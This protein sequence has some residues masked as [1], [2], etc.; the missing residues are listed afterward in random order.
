M[1][2]RQVLSISLPSSEVHHLQALSEDMEILCCNDLYSDVTFLVEDTK[3]PAHKV[4]LA[5]R[6]QYFRALLYGGLRESSEDVIELQDASKEAFTHVLRY[7]YAGCLSLSSFKEELLLEILGLSHKY[8]VGDLELA[9]CENLKT[10]LSLE[11]VCSIYDTAVLFS[12]ESL[13]NAALRFIDGRATDIMR[14]ESF[15]E[16]SPESLKSIFSRDSFYASE[17]EIFNSVC[18]WAR[19][20]PAERNNIPTI[21]ESVRFPLM[22]RLDLLNIVR[23]SGLVSP[24]MILDAM[25]QKETVK[26]TDLRRRGIIQPEENV[27]TSR[28]GATVEEGEMK[29]ALLDGDICNYDS[30]RGYTR[31]PI[32]EG[33]KG[34][35]IKLGAPHILNHFKMLLWDRDLRMYSYYIEVSID[36][37]QWT[38]VID[39][40]GVHCRSWQYLYFQEKVVRYIRIIGTFNSV[41]R[42]FHA[43][44]FQASYA[45]DIPELENGIIGPTYNVATVKLSAAMIEGVSRTRNALINESYTNYD[46]ENGY[47]CHQIGTGWLVIHL[48]QPY[49]ADSMR[50]LLWDCDD[51][52]YSYYIE[53]S[54]N[55]RDWTMVHDKTRERCRSWQHIRFEKRSFCYVRI[56]GTHNTANDVFHCVHFECPA[57]VS[58][59][60]KSLPPVQEASQ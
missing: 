32:E 2:R 37:S 36:D 59:M 40:T 38:R 60:D 49:A 9:I 7:L 46:W 57:Q 23:A 54:D 3:I 24:D 28:Y 30:E 56:V 51:R 6:S 18:E 20:N 52:Q 13:A 5:A 25:L 34:I 35:K 39:H 10:N 48:G 43:V 17:V 53:V 14:Q 12:L 22:T 1:S 15:K 27:A 44:A 21:L 4:I 33:T 16:L 41:N 47:T 29:S 42:T 26:E 55:G 31:H 11:N 8:S 19:A 58:D 50:M 45:S